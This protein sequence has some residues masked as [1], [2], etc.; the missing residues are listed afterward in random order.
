MSTVDKYIF[1]G[2]Q[3]VKGIYDLYVIYI[4]IIFFTRKNIKKG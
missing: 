1:Y 4:I 3:G 2:V